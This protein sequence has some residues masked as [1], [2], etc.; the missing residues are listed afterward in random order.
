MVDLRTCPDSWKVIIKKILNLVDT[1]E[2]LQIYNHER[3]M[4]EPW[5]FS[6]GFHRTNQTTPSADLNIQLNISAL[7]L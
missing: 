7:S 4:I 5:E 2:K 3:T 6:R 1:K